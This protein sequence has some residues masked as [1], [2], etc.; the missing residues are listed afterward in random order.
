[1]TR[2]LRTF[3]PLVA[4]VAW[5]GCSAPTSSSPTFDVT[6]TNTPDPLSRPPPPASSTR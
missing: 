5:A 1:M 3:L 2:V 4:G 6:L